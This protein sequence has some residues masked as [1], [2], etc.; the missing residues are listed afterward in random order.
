[1]NKLNKILLLATTLLTMLAP[2]KSNEMTMASATSDDVTWVKKNIDYGPA[3]FAYIYTFGTKGDLAYGQV[4][5]LFAFDDA[6]QD[7]DIINRLGFRVTYRKPSTV[8]HD[9]G[10]WWQNIWGNPP[11]HGDLITETF[12]IKASTAYTFEI[13]QTSTSY[14]ILPAPQYKD[15]SKLGFSAIGKMA[16]LKQ[17]ESSARDL[18]DGVEMTDWYLKNTLTGGPAYKPTAKDRINN[19]KFS[20]SSRKWYAIIPVSWSDE[21]LS[22]ESIDCMLFDGTHIRDGLNEDGEA[23]TEID[24]PYINSRYIDVYASKDFAVA[25]NGTNAKLKAINVDGYTAGNDTLVKIENSGWDYVNNKQTAIQKSYLIERNL[26]KTLDWTITD[27]NRYI[28]IKWGG[29]RADAE[30]IKIRLY[31]ENTNQEVAWIINVADKN[32]NMFPDPIQPD[33]PQELPEL[34]FDDLIVAMAI[35]LGLVIAIYLIWDVFKAL[36]V[37]SR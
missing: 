6:E 24:G 2:S 4:N 1:M 22:L 10:N 13:K 35:I 37:G 36:L 8:L 12:I 23:E 31:Y 17:A 27:S 3:D 34:Q 29:M 25:I 19:D 18:V 7:I 9:I 21:N 11:K 32:G 16:E 26:T 14:A 20:Y 5:I 30:K 33:R 15:I 28:F